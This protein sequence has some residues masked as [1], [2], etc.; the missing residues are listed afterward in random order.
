MENSINC[1]SFAPNFDVI[2]SMKNKFLGIIFLLTSATYAQEVEYINTDR[3]DQSEGVYTL[4]KG[5]FQVEDG[6]TFSDSGWANDLM[7]R[8]GLFN[9][10]ELRLASDLKKNKGQKLEVID[11]VL[12]FKQ[13]ILEEKGIFPAVTLVGYLTYQNPLKEWS[14]DAYIAFENNLSDKFLLC[15]NLGSSNFFKELNVTT[16]FGYSPVNQLYVYAEY[17]ATFGNQL[18][19]HNMDCGVL[20]CLT[21]NFQI[22]ISFGRSIFRQETDWFA[23]TGL[24][25]RFF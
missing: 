3:P 23:S 20:Y 15:Y 21:P 7:L 19:S 24:S 4:P 12:S 2:D 17:F 16:Q 18:P 11:V 5:N 1:H 10:T 13:H 6:F 14:T 25:Y 8:Y 22:D 9:G